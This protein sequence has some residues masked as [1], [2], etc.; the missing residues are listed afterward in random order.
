V[1]HDD[2]AVAELHGD[3]AD[4]TEVGER[5][6]DVAD[7]GRARHALHFENRCSSHPERQDRRLHYRVSR[8]V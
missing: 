3:L 6:G 8:Q 4:T 7:A 5:R 1:F 2:E